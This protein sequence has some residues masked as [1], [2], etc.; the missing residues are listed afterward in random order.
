MRS[1]ST[2]LV[3]SL[4]SLGA[5]VVQPAGGPPP[6]AH[7]VGP[8]PEPGPSRGV[9]YGVV[10]D[11][12][13]HQPMP[14]VGID[15]QDGQ[16]GPLVVQVITDANG[17]YETPPLGPNNYALRTRKD[18]YVSESRLDVDPAGGRAEVN[19]TIHRP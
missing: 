4:L 6:V 14:H 5:C 9:I 10:I 7:P 3:A 2:L 19:F 17:H 18:G 12:E 11:A 15:V 13:T 8:A 16:K 1:L